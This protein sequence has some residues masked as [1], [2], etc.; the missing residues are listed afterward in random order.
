[1]TTIST[2]TC[3]IPPAS[4]PYAVRQSRISRYYD[5]YEGC[6]VLP[7]TSSFGKVNP[8]EPWGHALVD[9][10]TVLLVLDKV[11]TGRGTRVVSGYMDSSDA[12]PPEAPVGTAIN[13]RHDQTGARMGRFF[14]VGKH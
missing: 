5:S 10:T 2:T 4:T 12:L 3:P 6:A 1:M 14:I 13:L 7:A 11:P 8:R 9:T